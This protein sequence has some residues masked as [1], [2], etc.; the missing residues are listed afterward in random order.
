MDKKRYEG[1]WN[2]FSTG[3][4]AKDYISEIEK[5]PVNE[6]PGQYQEMVAVIAEL[7]EEIRAPFLPP[8]RLITVD[9]T[10]K[11]PTTV[12]V[13][14]DVLQHFIRKASHRVIA[15]VCFCRLL[16]G[17]KDYSA[18]LGCMFFGE[19]AKSLPSTFGRTASIDEALAHAE[20]WR[21]AGLMPHLGYV[22]YDAQFFGVDPA[23][24]F[25]SVCGC[26][27]CCSIS[28]F[29][30]YQR[31]QGVEV[32]I[33]EACTGCGDCV[34]VCPTGCIDIVDEKACIDE[35]CRAC[36]WCVNACPEKA[37]EVMVVD[38]EYVQKTIQWISEKVDVT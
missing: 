6:K 16:T 37:I 26:C 34:E 20:K 17:C 25:M 3:D 21:E 36:G 31:M 14:S 30:K 1:L 11:N 27:P 32:R 19:P 8:A 35:E 2:M 18:D 33:S 9:E 38:P 28:R 5:S 12:Q 29:V 15:H 23:D 4:R 7:E 22:P 10:V 24:R 13:P